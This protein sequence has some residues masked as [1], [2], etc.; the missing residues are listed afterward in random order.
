VRVPLGE[1]LHI[2]MKW[3]FWGN[4][5]ASQP[6]SLE[7]GDGRD[8]RFP[9]G[10]CGLNHE[11]SDFSAGF[12]FLEMI[13][14]LTVA[15]IVLGAVFGLLTRS[16]VSNAVEMERS[17]LQDQARHALEL[18]SRDV[19]LAGTD[20]PPEFP[21]FQASGPTLAQAGDRIE[22]L[23][24]FRG[25]AFGAGPAPVETF[26]GYTARLADPP[27]FVAGDL[28]LFFDDKPTEGNWI[29]G[30]VGQVRNEPR[31]EIDIVTRE[32]ATVAGP[33][34]SVTLP[35]DVTR[36]NRLLQGF[37]ISGF[38]TPISVVSYE[39]MRDGS[40]SGVDASPVLLRRLDWGEPV[41]VAAIESMEIRYFVGGMVSGPGYEAPHPPPDHRFRI[42][43]GPESS[44]SSAKGSATHLGGPPPRDEGNRDRRY[45]DVEL[46]V[47]PTPQPDP[48]QTID[49]RGVVHGVRITVTSRSKR[50]N[51]TGSERLESDPP[52]AAGYIRQTLSTRVTPR[53]ILN[54][55]TRRVVTAELEG[56]GAHPSSHRR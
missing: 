21:S 11:P 42:Q 47:P 4:R 23:G 40:S 49:E 35:P 6:D 22:I 18:L 3:G 48:R 10:E 7:Q 39:V 29:V 45:N 5:P 28:V 50:A 36:Y 26:D 13:A 8:R 2:R 1:P 32:G 46:E 43:G 16:T 38:V 56:D 33:S 41:E 19:L 15:L 24:N 52:D 54:Q 31:P 20:L 37:P 30:V 9:W 44:S 53:N 14:S 55:A 25:D 34:G 12:S 27:Q 51:L 17:E